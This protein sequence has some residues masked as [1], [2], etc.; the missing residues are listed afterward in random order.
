MS[1]NV[2]VLL[3]LSLL[4]N[5]FCIPASVVRPKRQ[6]PSENTI[7]QSSD[8]VSR[9][10]T[11]SSTVN[12]DLPPPIPYNDEDD[13]DDDDLDIPKKY[14]SDDGGSNVFSL[15]KLVSGL[16]PASSGSSSKIYQRIIKEIMKHTKSRIII[17]R[18][19]ADNEIDVDY[20]SDLKP[21]PLQKQEEQ[22]EESD[23]SSKSS[24]N[25]SDDAAEESLEEEDERNKSEQASDSNLDDDDYDEPPGGGDGAGGGLLGLLAGLSGGE[26]GQSDL[27]SLLATIGG[28]VANLSGDGIDLNALI[29]SG[30][31]LFVGLLSEG[32]ENPG[33]V[34]ASYLLTSLD[35]ITG[36]GSKNNGEFFGK[37]LSKLIKGTS[38]GGDP[39]ASSEEENEEKPKDSAG[40]FLSFIMALL[41]DMSKGSSGS[42]PW[43]RYGAQHK[44]SDEPAQSPLWTLKLDI[45]RALVQFGTSII[46]IASSAVF[47][48]S[49]G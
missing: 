29:G 43:R 47:S 11:S 41:G 23:S 28:I 25:E 1:R 6:D 38:A 12:Y 18:S 2:S 42:Q 26:D 33:A 40:F 32:E 36:G 3:A 7:A 5:G 9:V 20:I 22:N 4:T 27:G 16:L 30:I 10:S 35:T 44:P 46:G 8:T 37:F 31:G 15:L 48:S 39:E 49:S 19:D 14:P 13:D 21:S 17:R 34:I 45:L 24:S